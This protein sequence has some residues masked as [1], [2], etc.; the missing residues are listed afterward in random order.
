LSNF[1]VLI[2][3]KLNEVLPENLKVVNLEV[4]LEGDFRVLRGITEEHQLEFAVAISQDPTLEE[5]EK[6]ALK[7]RDRLLFHV[8]NKVTK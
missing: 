3:S 5:I 6:I 1:L 4:N 8:A 2:D 7:L